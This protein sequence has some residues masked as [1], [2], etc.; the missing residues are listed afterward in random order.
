MRRH[1]NHFLYIPKIS[2]TMF[3]ALFLLP[4]YALSAYAIIHGVD[5]STLVSTATYKKAKA[6]GFTKAVIRGYEEAC[7]VGGLVDPNF[8][9]TYYN[10]RAAGFTNIDTYWFPCN[11]SGNK[12]K[13]YATQLAEISMTFNV[14]QM[15][16]GKIW[17]DIERDSGVCNNWNYGTAGNQAQAKEIIKALRNSGLKFGI[18][19]S[20]AVR[21]DAG[22]D[23]ILKEWSA[24]FGSRNFVLDNS[25][26]LWFTTFNNVQTLALGT[27][28]GGWT[29]AFG[30]QYTDV[31]ASHQFDLNVFAS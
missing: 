24:I 30:H 13:S 29:T 22:T 25:A 3:K 18:Y 11:G 28:F 9:P 7:V 16:I 12:C 8:V 15:N 26:P 5:S 2:T 21:F 1:L 14:N 27:P 6:E 4:V 19:S 17:V 10:A 23:A 31:S 20:P